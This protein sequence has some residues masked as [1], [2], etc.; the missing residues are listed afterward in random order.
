MEAR[1]LRCFWSLLASVRERV[2]IL[3][4]LG[5]KWGDIDVGLEIGGWG[6]V[7]GMVRDVYN[8]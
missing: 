5:G 1:V 4:V 8:T 6:D 3:R 7:W 2:D